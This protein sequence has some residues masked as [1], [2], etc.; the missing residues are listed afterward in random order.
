MNLLL[1]LLMLLNTSVEAFNKLSYPF[2]I[3][4][5]DKGRRISILS[6]DAPPHRH[7]A[8]CKIEDPHEPEL[9]RNHAFQFDLNIFSD[10]IQHFIEDRY[11]KHQC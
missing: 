6:R 8:F 10:R 9:I 7:Q 4:G 1:I 3:I 5:V 2:V 11:R